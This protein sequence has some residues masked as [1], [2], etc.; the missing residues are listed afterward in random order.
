[1]QSHLLFR[2]QDYASSRDHRRA[3][4]ETL[5]AAEQEKFEEL[6]TKYDKD[7]KGGLGFYELIEMGR[8]NRKIMDPVGW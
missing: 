4:A 1:M 3:H 5:Q 8:S 7:N 2:G 6:F